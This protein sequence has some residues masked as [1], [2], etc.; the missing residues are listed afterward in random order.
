[1]PLPRDPEKA[2]QTRKRMSE[3]AKKRFA[4][5]E[6]RDKLTAIRTEAMRRPEVRAKS[7]ARKKQFYEEHPEAVQ[8]LRERAIQQFSDPEVRLH[9]AEIAIQQFSDHPERGK[10]HSER[11]KK[12]YTQAESEYAKQRARETLEQT[13]QQPGY[14]ERVNEGMKLVNSDPV[15]QQNRHDGAIR[16]FQDPIKRGNLRQAM[17]I[18]NVDPDY[19]ASRRAGTIR[20]WQDDQKRDERGHKSFKGST[21]PTS[22]EIIVEQL[23]QALDVSYE[24]QWAIGRYVVDFYIPD[25]HLVIECDGEYWHLKPE[26]KARDARKDAFLSQRGYTILRLTGSQIKRGDFLSLEQ[27]LVG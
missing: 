26:A 9:H 15:V 1:M 19:R 25:K 7:S 13:R 21:K 8:A 12:F 16:A 6:E 5:L 18:V 23:L 11:L 4:N 24:S 17:Q 10:A 3:S 20:S 22:I 27:F 14:Q 2:A